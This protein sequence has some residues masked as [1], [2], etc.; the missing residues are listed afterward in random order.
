MNFLNIGNLPPWI[1]INERIDV[2]LLK[3]MIIVMYLILV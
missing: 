2:F 1:I 3:Y